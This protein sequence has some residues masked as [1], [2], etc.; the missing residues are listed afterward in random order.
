MKILKNRIKDNFSII[1]NSI[2]RD[3]NLRDGDFRLLIYLYSLPNDWKINQSNLADEM[4]CNLRNLNAKISRLKDGGYLEVIRRENNDY[5]YFLT[6]KSMSL[7]DTSLND[8]TSLNDTSLNDVYT[9]T[10]IYKESNNINIITKES[11]KNKHFV[12]P[13][14]DQ[15][16]NYC[17][18]RSNGIDP[19]YFYDFYESK[20]WMIGKNKMKDWKSAVRTW[21]KNRKKDV[22]TTK[23]TLERVAEG[24]YRF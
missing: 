6:E 5:D 2:I 22:S 10:N 13:S 1:P 12:K 20:D 9:N 16:R 23:P 18:E 11:N 4:N 14:I 19:E 3:K 8:V 21:E 24:V 7:N 17:D 15:I